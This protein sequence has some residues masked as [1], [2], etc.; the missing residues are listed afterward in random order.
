VRT[1][2]T[3]RAS[4]NIRDA[5]PSATPYALEYGSA[6]SR[7]L[8]TW[9]NIP[10]LKLPAAVLL[11]IG[12]ASP[13]SAGFSST[14]VLVPVVGEV[15]GADGS[16][17]SADVWIANDTESPAEVDLYF[18]AS[19]E[20]TP[21]LRHITIAPR[22]TERI[23]N[24]VQT[25]FHRTGVMG[26]LRVV[27]NVRVTVSVEVHAP[28]SQFT[29]AQRVTIPAIPV[30]LGITAGESSTIRGVRHNSDYRYN[31]FVAESVGS[32][33]AA[34]VVVLANGEQLAA[35]SV[36]LQPY[37]QRMI[38]LLPLLRDH[39]INDGSVVL[40][41]TAG[42]GRLV[43]VGS[44]VGRR[45]DATTFEMAFS[46][47]ALIGPPGPPGPAGPQGP[48]GA[49]GP[50]GPPGSE[51]P[52]GPEGPRGLSGVDG[53]VGPPG[54]QGP[55]GPAGPPGPPG[56]A[57]GTLARI[58]DASGQTVGPVVSVLTGSSSFEPTGVLKYRLPTGDFA[59]LWYTWRTNGRVTEA[60]MLRFFPM[61]SFVWF[62]SNDCT[63]TPHITHQVTPQPSQ[64]LIA[65]L[66]RPDGGVNLY[67]SAPNASLVTI[68]AR[69]F[70][71]SNGCLP[72]IQNREGV[73]ASVLNITAIHP[74][75]YRIVEP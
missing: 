35:T 37:E 44:L 21:S 28:G 68:G 31:L 42:M 17:Y 53:A 58:V 50:E 56:P 25:L 65:T 18:S 19:E 10:R 41:A 69:S 66:Q 27:S 60:Q 51:G 22:A 39:V 63:G 5:S 43:A 73:A 9:R 15:R 38:A 29:T 74:E 4:A 14:E 30:Q 11:V 71:G 52:P 24:I 47:S 12:L 33:I 6:S 23:E 34:D 46:T 36:I 72:V 64:R 3:G 16:D 13:V 8:A 48:P 45:G 49:R 26:S 67:Y 2:P 61:V 57:G 1:T 75:P 55:P 70:F 32:A 54:P 40:Q 7:L 62:A 59:L 20:P